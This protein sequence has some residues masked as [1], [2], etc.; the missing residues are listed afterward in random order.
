MNRPLIAVLLLTSG[1]LA[2]EAATDHLLTNPNAPASEDPARRPLPPRDDR[3]ERGE[4]GDRPMMDERRREMVRERMERLKDSGISREDMQKLRA[5][6]EGVGQSESVKAIRAEAQ[7]A[8]EAVRAAL[9]AY[10]KSKGLPAPGERSAEGAQ[11]ER[12][13]PG[14]MAEIRKAM[15]E[16]RDDPAVKAAF[17]QGK[18]VGQRLRDAVR[19][20]LLRRDATL[21]PILEK[22]GKAGDGLLELGSGRGDN[23]PRGPRGQG[24]FKGPREGEPKAPRDGRGKGPRGPRPETPS[25]EANPEPGA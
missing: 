16:A 1:L 23:A 13:S 14:R 6:L 25:A 24:E 4:R 9:Q 17:E 2:Q 21:A 12:P 10:A 20:E 19:E 7:K 3:A 22:L 8:R 15:E 5:A 18:A 11:P